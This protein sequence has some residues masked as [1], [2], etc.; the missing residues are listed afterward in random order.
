MELGQIS[1]LLVLHVGVHTKREFVVVEIENL[2]G[3]LVTMSLV[4]FVLL[5]LLR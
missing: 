1:L 3:F 5:L 4:E 2:L